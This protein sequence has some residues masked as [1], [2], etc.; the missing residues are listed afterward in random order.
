MALKLR[1]RKD[2][3]KEVQLLFDLHKLLN[4]GGKH[5]IKGLWFSRRKV[6]MCYCLRGGIQK[7]APDYR[8]YDMHIDLCR[9]V[10]RGIR[11][12]TGGTYWSIIGYN[13][14]R[15]TEWPDIENVIR[16]SIKIGRGEYV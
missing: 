6:G 4:H 7:V 8:N 9:L 10:E 13:D 3:P 11:K 5:W 16:E 1:P 2:D 15:A 14:A 12:V